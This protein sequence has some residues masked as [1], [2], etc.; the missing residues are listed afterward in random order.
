MGLYTVLSVSE[1]KTQ[2]ISVPLMQLHFAFKNDKV[3]IMNPAIFWNQT[4]K[5]EIHLDISLNTYRESFLKLKE[6]CQL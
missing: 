3:V 1:C 4:N 2:L 5:Y 6:K